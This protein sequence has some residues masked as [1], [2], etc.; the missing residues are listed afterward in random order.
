MDC[1]IPSACSPDKPSSL[2]KFLIDSSDC[3]K[4]LYN[5]LLQNQKESREQLTALRG[6]GDREAMQKTMTELRENLEKEMKSIFNEQQWAAYEQW[7]KD[8][9]PMQRRRRGG[10]E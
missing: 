7:K 10:G 6:N 4:K 5:V 1:L 8:N 3:I 9:P 2:F